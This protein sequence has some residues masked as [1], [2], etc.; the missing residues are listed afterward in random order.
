MR[1]PKRFKLLAHTVEVKADPFLVQRH[2]NVGRALY[3]EDV[4]LYQPACDGYSV[5]RETEEHSFVHELIHHMLVF[6]GEE[7]LSRNEKFVD[8]FAGLLHQAFETMEY[9][10]KPKGKGAK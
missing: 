1:I 9:E 5:S 10:D 6:M 2:D 7:E 4:I 3:Q 8:L